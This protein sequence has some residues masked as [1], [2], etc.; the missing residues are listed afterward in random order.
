MPLIGPVIG[1]L[2]TLLSSPEKRAENRADVKASFRTKQSGIEQEQKIKGAKLKATLLTAIPQLPILGLVSYKIQ[3]RNLLSL[4][5]IHP[6]YALAFFRLVP[7]V[8]DVILTSPR[9][10]SIAMISIGS[11]ILPPLG[12]TL[13]EQP[14][15]EESQKSP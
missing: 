7:N 1:L 2:V 11:C 8:V 6:L 4:L 13:L 15:S 10:L 12:Y 9:A 5:M 3:A 14:H